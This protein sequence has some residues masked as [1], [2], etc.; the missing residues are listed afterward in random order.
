MISPKSL[1]T[2]LVLCLLPLAGASASQRVDVDAA[3][4][5]ARQNNC[6]RCHSIGK[7][8][9]GPAWKKVARKYQGQPDAEERLVEHVTSGEKARFPDGHEEEH[10]IVRTEP[11]RD[12]EQIRNLVDWILSL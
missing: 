5:L 9:E 12:L 8:N 3:R 7:D 11:P 10:R 2:L 4:V 6:F 1:P